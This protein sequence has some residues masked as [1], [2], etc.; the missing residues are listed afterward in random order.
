MAISGLPR[1]SES[2]SNIAPAAA[3]KHRADPR[4]QRHLSGFDPT[5]LEQRV[6][7]GLIVLPAIT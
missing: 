1:A 3:L 2:P 7:S 6:A 4:D 5:T